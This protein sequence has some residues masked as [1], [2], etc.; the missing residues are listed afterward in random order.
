MTKPEAICGWRTSTCTWRERV[1]GESSGRL[2][3]VRSLPA[4]GRGMSLTGSALGG[5]DLGL[6]VPGGLA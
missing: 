2:L 5:S 3:R 1:P 6:V 4:L